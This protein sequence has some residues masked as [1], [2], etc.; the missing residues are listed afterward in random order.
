MGDV[1]A[2]LLRPFDLSALPYGDGA[3]TETAARRAALGG[4]L[5]LDRLLAFADVDGPALYPPASPSGFRHLLAAIHG[6]NVDRLKRDCFVYYLARDADAAA[7]STSSQTVD[8]MDVDAGSNPDTHPRAAAFARARCLPRTW[9][10]FIDGYWHLDHGEWDLAVECLR[11]PSIP[12][13]NF[14]PEIVGALTTLVAPPSHSLNLVHAFLTP[15][16]LESKVEKDAALLAAASVAGMSAAF[17]KIRALDDTDART[18]AREAVW[19]WSLGA[20]RS[21]AGRGT[22][23]AQPKALRELLHLAL[24]D[25]EHAHLVQLLAQPPR[26]ISAPARSLLHD[27]VTLRLVHD[28]KYEET[29]AL[30]KELAG[31]DA[32]S[33]ADRQRRREMV[34]E[35]IDILPEAQRRILLGDRAV[36]HVANGE[37]GD[38]DMSRSWIDVAADR[39]ASASAS[40]AAPA[41]P[42]VAAPSTPAR[43]VAPTPIRAPALRNIASSNGT[44]SRT[45]TSSPFGGPPRFA[46]APIA[47]PR[48]TSP[49]RTIGSPAPSKQPSPVRA[50]R[51]LTPEA[52]PAPPPVQRAASPPPRVTAN[53]FHPP[54]SSSKPVPARKPKRIIDDTPRRSSRRRSEAPEDNEDTLMQAPSEPPIPEDEPAPPTPAPV[55]EKTPARRTRR[56]TAHVKEASPTPTVEADTTPTKR[57]TRGVGRASRASTAE[58]AETEEPHFPGAFDAKPP[59]STRSAAKAHLD[60]PEPSAPEPKRVRA[61]AASKP[62]PASTPATRRTTRAM[63]EMTDDGSVAGDLPAT[64]RRTRRTVAA[65]DRGSPTPSVAG[66]S[67]AGSPTRRRTTRAVSA[68]P[69][70]TRSRK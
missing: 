28:G 13:V 5:F 62:T 41:A 59:R 7:W 64:G 63:S 48:P 60:E 51:L 49:T 11:D 29:L 68:T 56:A 69:R 67:V 43:V 16:E 33:A 35:F 30:D 70:Q 27:L 9:R 36:E 50:P 65:S 23:T 21:P 38:V 46:A 12:A 1:P 31:T 47:S 3:V 6:S 58:T 17:G 14:V 32:A 44:P 4:K 2:A 25:E 15:R 39:S 34:R 8:T 57:T 42:P 45:G 61:K 24:S 54:A 37:S 20:P 10:L 52:V 40:A 26:D 18:K 19:C 66:S 22:Y 53:P 55:V